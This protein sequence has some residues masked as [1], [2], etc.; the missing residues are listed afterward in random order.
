MLG[1]G[2]YAYPKHALTQRP[3]LA[4]DVVE[5][6]PAVTR[7][8]HRWFS[9]DEL[10]QIAGDRLRLIEGDAR[11]YLSQAIAEGTRYDAIVNDCFTGAEPARSL[12]TVEALCQVKVCLN[13]GGLYLANI[14]SSEDGENVDFLRDAAATAAAVFEHIHVVPCE[15]AD[16]GVEDNYLLIAT[17]AERTFEGEMPIAPEI[18]GA[19]LRDCDLR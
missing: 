13:P 16:F 1:G 7:L 5:L 14:V 12:A 17:D 2:G 9:L 6:D 11:A 19:V 4:M 3:E 8:A 15:D 10:E 18:L